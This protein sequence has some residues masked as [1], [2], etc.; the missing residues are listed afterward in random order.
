MAWTAADGFG[1][2]S[3]MFSDALQ[4][5]FSNMDK[6]TQPYAPHEFWAALKQMFPQFGQTTNRGIPMQQVLDESLLASSDV[7]ITGR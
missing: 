7:Q 3:R 6:T 5:T 1:G 4:H 2:G